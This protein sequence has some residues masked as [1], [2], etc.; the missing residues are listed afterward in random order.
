MTVLE[1]VSRVRH[2]GTATADGAILVTGS[3]GFIGEVVLRKLSTQVPHRQQLCAGRSVTADF[4]LDLSSDEIVVPQGIDTIVHLAGEKRDDWGMW[5]V[6]CEGTRRLVKAAAVAGVRRFV[7]LSSVGVYGADPHSGRIDE[8]LTHAPR[9]NYELSKNAGEQAVRELCPALGL[10]WV[11]LQPSNVLGVVTGRS[12]PLLGLMRAI[13]R[14][15]FFQIGSRRAWV[16]YVAV[17]DVA[18]AIVASVLSPISGCAWIINTPALV[19]DVVTWAAQELEVAAP[20]RRLPLAIGWGVAQAAG[21]IARITGR[22]LPIDPPRFRE[23]TSTTVYDGS[24]I[25]RDIGFEY[26]MGVEVLVRGLA[27]RYREENLL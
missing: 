13:Q 9:N 5:P 14:G 7:H 6:N 17:E 12:Y 15:R 22:A 26:R 3:R 27:R 23:L 2:S 1:P 4:A 16:N 8:C 11:V 24:A 18:D 21:L 25:T 19:D 10:D 20:M